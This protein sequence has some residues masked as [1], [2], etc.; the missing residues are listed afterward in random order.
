MS[1]TY[2]STSA[3][4]TSPLII[5]VTSPPT[6]RLTTLALETE[7]PP[8]HRHER[9]PSRTP[10]DPSHWLR[11]PTTITLGPGRLKYAVQP[12]KREGQ[13]QGVASLEDSNGCSKITITGGLAFEVWSRVHVA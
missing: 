6:M 11:R 1:S 9:T 12:L 5:D 4:T 3:T 13:R 7:R 8:S 10:T 2:L